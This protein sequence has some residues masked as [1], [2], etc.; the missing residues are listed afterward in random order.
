MMHCYQILKDFPKWAEKREPSRS[1]KANVLT[2]G[3]QE[4]SSSSSA[5]PVDSAECSEDEETAALARPGGRKAGK[6]EAKNAKEKKAA[7]D[8][9]CEL[10]EELVRDSKRKLD[11]YL[12]SKEQERRARE[13]DQKAKKEERDER[14]MAIDVNAISCTKRRRYYEIIQD[15]ILK[16]LELEEEKRLAADTVNEDICE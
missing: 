4:S 13:E 2:S 16:A 8:K 6:T 9:L 14:I 15:R 5:V 12:E 3:Q 10:H 11:V 7:V 1:S